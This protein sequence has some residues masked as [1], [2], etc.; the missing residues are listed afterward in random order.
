MCNKFYVSRQKK[1]KK[2][3]PL[4]R[5]KDTNPARFSDP[6]WPQIDIWLHNIARRC[7]A[8]A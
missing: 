6:K 8:D 4:C 5:C 7:Q 1:K 2:L 3:E